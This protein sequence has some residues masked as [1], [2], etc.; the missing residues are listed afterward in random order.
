[1]FKLG[2]LDSFLLGAGVVILVNVV[3]IAQGGDSVSLAFFGSSG[4]TTGF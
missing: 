4:L 3:L 2:A 1:M